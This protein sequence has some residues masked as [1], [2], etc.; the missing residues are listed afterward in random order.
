MPPMRRKSS[1][2]TVSRTPC[3]RRSCVLADGAEITSKGICKVTAMVESEER[4][5]PFE[6]LPIECP[7]ISVR[8]V[9]QKGNIV[10]LHRGE[11]ETE[12]HREERN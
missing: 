2:R 4:L 12:G 8:K 7:I 9:V 6:D 1:V 3:T 11:K 5:I 10:K